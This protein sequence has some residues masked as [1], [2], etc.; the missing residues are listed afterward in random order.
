MYF[1][2]RTTKKMLRL[3]LIFSIFFLFSSQVVAAENYLG[4]SSQKFISGVANAATG[5]AELPK[6]IILVSQKEGPLYGITIGTAQG[7]LHTVG[8]SLIG[9]LDA[10]TFLIPNK[11]PLNPPYIWQDL[12]TET[13]Y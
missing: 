11:S 6:N 7:L 2:L 13:S 12:S 3:F 5:F 4:S 1:Q 9:I 10:A 8:R